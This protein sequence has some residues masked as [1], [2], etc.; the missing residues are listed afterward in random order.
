MLTKRKPGTVDEEKARSGDFFRFLVNSAQMENLLLVDRSAGNAAEGDQ[1]PFLEKKR[2]L[3]KNDGGGSNSG[4]RSAAGLDFEKE[5]GNKTSCIPG[6][7][8]TFFQGCPVVLQPL[9]KDLKF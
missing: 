5:G 6:T 2:F 1:K 4:R 7:S 3:G 8:I 9:A